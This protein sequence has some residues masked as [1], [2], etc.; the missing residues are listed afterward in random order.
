M[1]NEKV[2]KTVRKH[3]VGTSSDRFDCM[4]SGTKY[5]FN[6][7]FTL[8]KLIGIKS[9]M[10]ATPGQGFERYIRYVKMLGPK[11]CKKNV[12]VFMEIDKK[13]FKDMKKETAGYRGIKTYLFDIFHYVV[14]TKKYFRIQDLSIGTG[15]T[16]TID[17]ATSMLRRQ[18]EHLNSSR[19]WKA[20]VY[21]FN[22]R[23][24]D[25][26]NKVILAGLK[27]Y[28]SALGLE[29]ESVNG[30][31]VD[32]DIS[33]NCLLSDNAVIVSDFSE[34]KRKNAAHVYEHTIA[35]KKNNKHAIMHVYSYLNGSQM[36]ATLIMYK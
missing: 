29:I 13:R 31:N 28:V 12:S 30:V 1:K 25:C 18:Y 11:S 5:V 17:H 16:T 20:Q 2:I 32:K 7:I 21:S 23:N 36:W 22:G 19:R 26:S 34:R 24:K 15:I 27:R 6:T 4:G 33:G 14:K 8:M 10:I 9:P 3:H 35:F